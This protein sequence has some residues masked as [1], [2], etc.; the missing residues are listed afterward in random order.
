MG[1]QDIIASFQ[2]QQEAARLSN[3]Q[4]Y[5]QALELYDE[6]IS[7]YQPEGG[8]LTGAKAELEREK[9]REVAGQTQG[10]VSSG[11]FGTSLTAGLGQ[12]WEVERGQ[13]ARLKLEDVRMGRLAEALQ[14]KAG[15]IERREDVGP[16]Y[17]TIAQLS[18]QAGA[19]PS[20]IYQQPYTP[21]TSYGQ[22]QPFEQG[23]TVPYQTSAAYNLGQGGLL[24]P[25]QPAGT[26]T[27]AAQPTM[28]PQEY[29]AGAQEFGGGTQ[30]LSQ[31]IF[32][33]M[34]GYASQAAGTMGA[35]GTV[36]GT[37]SPYIEGHNYAAAYY[38]KTGKKLSQQSAYSALG[39]SYS[40]YGSQ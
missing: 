11:L 31:D 13:P 16:D 1:Y 5:A 35:G 8:F 34:S 38:R 19:R 36:G 15:V 4:R 17:A 6:I 25:R 12:K 28:T 10:L 33:A 29:W 7:Q 3:E 26:Q 30:Q 18:A 22:Y 24:R 37:Q 14:A 21:D 32:G 20:T 27:T 39:S 23:G 9:G 2:E 40:P